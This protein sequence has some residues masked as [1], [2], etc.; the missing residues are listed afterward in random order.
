MTNEA[1][2]L[3]AGNLALVVAVVAVLSWVLY[4]NLRG[5][6]GAVSPSF[7]D[8]ESAYSDLSQQMDA[9][10]EQQT[11]DHQA[12]RQLRA[13]VLR[14]DAD[15]Q[16]WRL[17]YAKLANEF[18]A[19]TGHTPTAKPPDTETAAA[20]A[21][22]AGLDRG[23]LAQLMIDAFSIEE[24]DGLAFEME[25][26]TAVKG[27]TAEARARSLV[28]AARRRKRLDALIA[29]CRRERPEGGF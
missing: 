2:A 6:V 15:L 3:L 17:A 5:R 25:L 1:A 27:E 8:L 7:V 19:E 9:M 10:R 13:E 28:D 4:S 24:I 21:T 12:I 18:M 11:A 20:V 29:L 23:R 14:I 16:R 26:T 22:G